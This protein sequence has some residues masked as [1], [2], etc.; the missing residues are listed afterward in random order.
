MVKGV[1]SDFFIVRFEF[2]VSKFVA[3]PIFRLFGVL[4]NFEGWGGGGVLGW[5]IVF[6]GV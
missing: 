2:P 5:G 3:V 6:T 4:F 1:V